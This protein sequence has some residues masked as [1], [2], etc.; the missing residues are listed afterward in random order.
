M[1]VITYS[2]HDDSE[3]TVCDLCYPLVL[4]DMP[5]IAGV[6]PEHDGWCEACGPNQSEE[7]RQF[8]AIAAQLDESDQRL[9]LAFAERLTRS[10]N[11][12]VL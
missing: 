4:P 12:G 3:T 8:M 2:H 11:N 7:V 9:L 1:K 6:G 10:G 5:A